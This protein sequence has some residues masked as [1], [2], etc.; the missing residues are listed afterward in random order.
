[1]DN[2]EQIRSDV[3]TAW[4]KVLGKDNADNE[5]GAAGRSFLGQPFERTYLDSHPGSIVGSDGSDNKIRARARLGFDM[6][7]LDLVAD[8][9]R[10]QRVSPLDMQMHKDGFYQLAEFV[11]LLRARNKDLGLD[12]NDETALAGKIVERYGSDPRRLWKV[13]SHSAPFLRTLSKAIAGR[14]ISSGLLGQDAWSELFIASELTMQLP[15]LVEIEKRTPSARDFFPM[16]FLNAPGAK[17][18]EFRTLDRRARAEHTAT[19]EGDAPTAA[20]TSTP[21]KRPLVW[22]WSGLS[23]SWLDLEEWKMARSN[24][25]PLPDIVA[26]QTRTA[27]EALLELENIDLFFGFN[28]VKGASVLGLLTQNGGASA[29]GIPQP[30]AVANFADETDSEVAVQ[31]LLIGVKAI[32]QAQRG[33]RDPIVI[34]LSTRDYLAVTSASYKD[35]TS[36]GEKSIAQVALD[37]GKAMGLQA[38]VEIPELGYEAEVKTYLEGIG[39][40]SALATKFAGG[41]GG[42][43]V[44]LTMARSPDNCRGIVGQDV[45]QFPPDKTSTLT[46][47][48]IASSTGGLEVKQP[49][50][51]HLQIIN[52][53]S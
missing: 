42:K 31:R 24:G 35:A 32:Y 26:L 17:D 34:A 52:D 6:A 37:R 13:G 4:S 21:I 30:A 33:R 9:R 47:I 46:K 20:V 40:S 44:M 11:P 15:E 38:I 43:A 36:K 48:K 25:S 7:R 12:S 51:L 41:I 16:R 8:G 50:A 10:S 27:R 3:F 49:K 39:Y 14:T 2:I 22:M 29:Q 28:V 45:M 23:F 19:F 1:M 53:P 18:Y 5:H